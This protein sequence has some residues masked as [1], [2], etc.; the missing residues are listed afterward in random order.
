MAFIRSLV[1]FIFALFIETVEAESVP[2]M[3]MAIITNT[4][5]NSIKLKALLRILLILRTSL[6]DDPIAEI[7]TFRARNYVVV[8]RSASAGAICNLTIKGIDIAGK[9][10]ANR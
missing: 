1:T 6:F 2:A 4:I 10:S 3:T 7:R 9:R 5:D 8:R